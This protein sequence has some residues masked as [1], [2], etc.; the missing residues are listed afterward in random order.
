MASNSDAVEDALGNLCGQCGFG[1][2]GPALAYF[3]HTRFGL[4][5]AF[6]VRR[7]RRVRTATV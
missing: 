5:V 7:R 4:L 2:G 6:T 3:S 1:T